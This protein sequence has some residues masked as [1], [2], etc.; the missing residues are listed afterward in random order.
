[1][2]GIAKAS[3]S[4]PF[5]NE[6]YVPFKNEAFVP[7]KNAA[8]PIIFDFERPKI[9]TLLQ[10]KVD[11]QRTDANAPS[12]EKDMTDNTVLDFSPG[13]HVNFTVEGMIRSDGRLDNYNVQLVEF[14]PSTAGLNGTT[15]GEYR[16]RVHMSFVTLA[17]G[18]RDMAAN[19]TENSPARPLAS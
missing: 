19:S 6:A 5:N 7:F 15:S 14:V 13:G 9:S 10:L 18:V 16:L 12:N 17:T 4:S 8:L 11:Y 1:M 3:S 2:P